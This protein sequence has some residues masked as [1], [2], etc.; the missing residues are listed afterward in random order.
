VILVDR[1]RLSVSFH[2]GLDLMERIQQLRTV[3]VQLRD[4]RAQ[5]DGAFGVP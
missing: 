2:G 4:A 5:A 3:Q 1:E